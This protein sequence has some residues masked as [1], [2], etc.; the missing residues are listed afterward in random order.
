MVQASSYCSMS[1]GKSTTFHLLQ[2]GL[3]LKLN[4]RSYRSSLSRIP[5]RYVCLW[6]GC[7]VTC[8]R[9]YEL[10]RHVNRHK[11]RRC[12]YCPIS[13]CNFAS[14]YRRLGRLWLTYPRYGS[15]AA[16]T[17][18]CIDKRTHL[19]TL[20]GFSRLDKLQKHL[21]KEHRQIVRISV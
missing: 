20:L 13:G 11:L 3:L 17:T 1:Q 2:R 16:W 4:G 9:V 8:K 5:E 12:W 15:S 21:K 6:P 10:K 7:E 18:E 19:P 14:D